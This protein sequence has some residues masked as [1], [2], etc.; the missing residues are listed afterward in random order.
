[1][2]FLCLQNR[3]L[4]SDEA[5]PQL[6][7]ID[8][9]HVTDV[10]CTQNISDGTVD[11]VCRCC[12]PFLAFWTNLEGSSVEAMRAHLSDQTLNLAAPDRHQLSAH[13]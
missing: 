1:M 13:R 3:P 2:G 10:H 5:R 12:M 11:V 8:V 9:V 4:A 6:N 7:V